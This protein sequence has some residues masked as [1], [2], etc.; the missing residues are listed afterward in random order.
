MWGCIVG[1]E[2]E[3]NY[4]H[5][6]CKDE[7]TKLN[8]KT[9]DLSVKVMNGLSHRVKRIDR[10]LWFVGTSVFLLLLKEIMNII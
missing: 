2:K 10:I 5:E 4:Y 6:F 1:K 9:D 8:T 7:F 3:T